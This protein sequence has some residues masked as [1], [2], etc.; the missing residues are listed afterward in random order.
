MEGIQDLLPAGF[1]EPELRRDHP[2][3]EWASELAAMTQVSV[4][5]YAVGG[6]FL[7]LA[8]FD[9]YYHLVAILV[10]TDMIVGR[11]LVPNAGKVRQRFGQ[12][13][14]APRS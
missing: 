2:E 5:G 11:Q 9:L 14:L 1:G 3:L 13:R 6:M 12:P 8:Y 7:G 10:L 4:V